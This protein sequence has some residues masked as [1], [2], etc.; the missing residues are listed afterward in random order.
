M[1]QKIFITRRKHWSDKDGPDILLSDWLEYLSIDPSLQH[2]PAFGDDKGYGEESTHV[3]WTEWPHQG[4]GREARLTLEGGNVVASNADAAVRQKLFVMAHV[5]GAKVQGLRGEIYDSIG[6]PERRVKP[7]MKKSWWRFWSVLLTLIF[8]FAGQ[9]TEAAKVKKGVTYSKSGQKLDLCRPNGAARD[10]GLIFI[11]G[12]GFS[13]GN[14]DSM[15]GYC[16]LLADGGFPSAT[17]SYRLTSQGH[18]FPAAL[19]DVSAAVNWMRANTGAK[20]IV[21]IGYSAGGTL[22]MTAGLAN[23]SGIAGIVSSAGI[24]D[25]ASIRKSTPHAKLRRDID[26]YL[27]GA[28]AA[29][30]SPVNQVSRGDPPVFLF[31]GK[32]DNLVPV[33]QSVVM[34]KA[35]KSKGVKVLFRA[36]DNAGHEIMLPNKHLKSLLQDMTKFLVAI[37]KS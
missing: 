23:G 14:R 7:S 1:G 5:L 15:F 22:A 8:A 21:L 13:S 29:V 24:A 3:V 25:F 34:S 27:G 36:Y 32:N 28:T 19:Q 17:I 31:H 30:A 16:K 18:A 33:S 2:D 37:D 6:R 4:G 20:K 10:T 26:A 35:L 12:G 11:H 9:P